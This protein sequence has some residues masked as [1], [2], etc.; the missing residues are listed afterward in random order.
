MDN[1]D[2]AFD[3]YEQMLMAGDPALDYYDDE[4]RKRDNDR[5]DIVCK[6]CGE[7]NLKWR[8]VDSKW[9]L[10]DEASN[11]HSCDEFIRHNKKEKRLKKKMDKIHRFIDLNYSD[12]CDHHDEY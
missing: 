12:I 1:L 8:H 5:F 10:Y 2:I 7:K 6:H 9:R 3:Q 11:I 4:D